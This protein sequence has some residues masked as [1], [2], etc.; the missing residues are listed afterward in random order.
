LL[1][2]RILAQATADPGAFEVADRIR[3]QPFL[4]HVTGQ[5][6]TGDPLPDRDYEIAAF[7]EPHA[8]FA[9]IERYVA[10]MARLN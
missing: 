10:E 3:D 1:Q 6:E 9:G 5:L 7:D 4:V 8:A 2:P